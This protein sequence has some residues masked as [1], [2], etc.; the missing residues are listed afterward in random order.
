MVKFK[1]FKIILVALNPNT[2]TCSLI[3]RSRVELLGSSS[4]LASESMGHEGTHSTSRP[5]LAGEPVLA[6]FCKASSQPQNP[7]MGHGP[8]I[9]YHT[10]WRKKVGISLRMVFL[11]STMIICKLMNFTPKMGKGEMTGCK[12]AFGCCCFERENSLS[13]VFE[14]LVI[15]LT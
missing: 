3:L 7:H 12:G 1:I 5:R 6:F 9:E 8:L 15:L 13:L 14:I 11:K 2:N 10:Y 4:P